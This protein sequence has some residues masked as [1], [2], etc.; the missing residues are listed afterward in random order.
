MHNIVFSKK[1]TE[2]LIEQ[3]LYIYEQTQIIEIS[4]RYLDDMKRFIVSILTKFPKSG[5]ASEDILAGSRKI[6]Y[7]GYS[8]IYQIS[9]ERIEILTI[10]RKNLKG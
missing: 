2:A 8:I 6:V 4:D 5:R 3:A 10:Y 1:A 7:K 9:G